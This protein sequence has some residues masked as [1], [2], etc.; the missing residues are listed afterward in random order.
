MG[1]LAVVDVGMGPST[2]EPFGDLPGTGQTL[3]HLSGAVPDSAHVV[4]CGV[5]ISYLF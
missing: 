4:L 5:S 1:L 2:R 3:P